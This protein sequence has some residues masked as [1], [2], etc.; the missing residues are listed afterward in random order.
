MP[1]PAPLPDA[2]EVRD[3]ATFAAIL[4]ALSRPG[5]VHRLPEPGP[6]PIVGALLDRECRAWADT[7]EVEMLIRGS[8]ATVVPPDLAGHLFLSFDTD[9]QLGRLARATTGDQLYPDEGAT[10]VA[11]ARIGDG[12]E[13]RLAGPGVDGTA[14]LRL[15]GLHPGLWPVRASLC[16]Y[17]L[18]V[19]M[20]LVDG[21]RIAAL[22]RST[23]VEV[24]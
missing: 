20:I 14:R 7:P 1:A 17:P 8:G 11:P 4:A 15:G 3:N 18:G 19:E 22:P 5:T 23:T 16:R 13:L 2:A 21:D 10:I 6:A 24:P 9:A 12:P